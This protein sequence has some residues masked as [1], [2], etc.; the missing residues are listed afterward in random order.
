MVLVSGCEAKLHVVLERA[1]ADDAFGASANT[2]ERPLPVLAQALRLIAGQPAGASSP[3]QR[4][5]KWGYVTPLT[6]AIKLPHR[7]HHS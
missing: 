5:V 1:L 4:H 3:C 6:V 7:F 2:P